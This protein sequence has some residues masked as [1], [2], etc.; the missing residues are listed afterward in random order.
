MGFVS[1]SLPRP[2]TSRAGE[3]KVEREGYGR[4]M[5]ELPVEESPL[6]PVPVNPVREALLSIIPFPLL[7]LRFV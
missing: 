7:A 3:Y 2:P 4:R 1:L 6:N 5:G